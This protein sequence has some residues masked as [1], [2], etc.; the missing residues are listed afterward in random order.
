MQVATLYDIHGNLR[1]LEA[2]LLEIPDE[3]TIVV[4]GDVVAVGEQP[5]ETL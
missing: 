2:V 5:A 4:G 3:A 1:A